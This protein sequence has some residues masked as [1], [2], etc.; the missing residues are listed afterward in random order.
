M[1]T[2]SDFDAGFVCYYF[3]VVTK[4]IDVILISFD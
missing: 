1:S 2:T 4:I 3:R